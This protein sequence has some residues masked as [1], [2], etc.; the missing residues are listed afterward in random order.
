MSTNR[1]V[2]DVPGNEWQT[3][4]DRRH[5]GA[6]AART[7]RVRARTVALARSARLVAP[8]PRVRVVVVVR[9]RTNR[10]VDPANAY[11]T[12][13]AAIDGMTDAGVWEDDDRTHVVGPDMRWGEPVKGLRPGWHRLEFTLE[14]DD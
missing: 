11:P 8:G 12:I 6:K 10:R 3:S 13:K 14:R 1:L 5:W 4:N 9:G 2:V 7:R